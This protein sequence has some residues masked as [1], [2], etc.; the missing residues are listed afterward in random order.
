MIKHRPWAWRLDSIS[1]PCCPVPGFVTLIDSWLFRFGKRILEQEL[2]PQTLCQ[3]V[4]ASLPLPL[5]LRHKVKVRGLQKQQKRGGGGFITISNRK[6]IQT[7]S[8]SVHTCIK[9]L[10]SLYR[11]SK[12][13]VT[14]TSSLPISRLC[15]NCFRFPKNHC[16]REL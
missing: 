14:K 16:W 4:S 11:A 13:W 6:R 7:F 1:T 5:D 9:K 10:S 2:K 12:Q 3:P 8:L 15:N